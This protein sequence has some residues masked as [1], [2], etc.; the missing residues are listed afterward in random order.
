[1]PIDDW[2]EFVDRVDAAFA[3]AN[4][5]EAL[6][7]DDDYGAAEAYLEQTIYPLDGT[8]WD[9]PG[10]PTATHDV[11]RYQQ[12]LPPKKRTLVSVTSRLLERFQRGL[13]RFQR[14]S[15]RVVEFAAQLAHDAFA[16]LHFLDYEVK[17]RGPRWPAFVRRYRAPHNF[18]AYYIEQLVAM[19]YEE[20][21]PSGRDHPRPVERTIREDLPSPGL[22]AILASA[23]P[24]ALRETLLSLRRDRHRGMVFLK[25]SLLPDRPIGAVLG[26]TKGALDTAFSRAR[27]AERVGNRLVAI[28][29]VRG[30]ESPRA[31]GEIVLRQ[32]ALRRVFVDERNLGAAHD[33]STG[34]WEMIGRAAHAILVGARGIDRVVGFWAGHS[35]LVEDPPATE[36]EDEF[37]RLV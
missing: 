22:R 14:G 17:K 32:S 4:G 23:L 7:G 13:E 21:R 27:F 26:M 10:H 36:F 1:L 31:L 28:E 29:E 11:R 18:R 9:Q 33:P 35:P 3:R 16:T 20:I 37:R 30:I 25:Y 34:E 19:A 2:D 5:G 6:L 12:T 15:D 24:R 8:D